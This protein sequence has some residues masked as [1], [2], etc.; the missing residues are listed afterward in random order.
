MSRAGK[1]SMQPKR[2]NCA[3]ESYQPWGKG[4]AVRLASRNKQTC[5]FLAVR[6]IRLYKKGLSNS[7]AVEGLRACS[8][9]RPLHACGRS[10]RRLVSQHAQA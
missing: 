6:R 1:P 8:F 9:G 2:P 7:F 5:L 3:I 4:T 10:L